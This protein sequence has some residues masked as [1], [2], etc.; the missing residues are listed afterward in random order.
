M[1]VFQETVAKVRTKYVQ[2]TYKSS[3]STYKTNLNGFP[4]KRNFE[5]IVDNPEIYYNV[6]HCIVLLKGS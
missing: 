2:S 1:P 3:K 4:K 6:L 5:G